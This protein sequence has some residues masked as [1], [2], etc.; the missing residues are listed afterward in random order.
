[1][2]APADCL[3]ERDDITDRLGEIDCPALVIHGT[4]DVV[5]RDG[6]RRAAV[7]GPRP[8]A[9]GVTRIEGGTHA[10][11]LTHPAEVNAALLEFLRGPLA[12]RRNV[13]V[14][15]QRRTARSSKV[16][17][18]LRQQRAVGERALEHAFT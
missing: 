17:F 18:D 11:N 16:G 10:A 9:Q 4:A 2:Q 14:R 3:F 13:Q 1:M 6:A 5:D 15:Q 8:A 7:R 12:R